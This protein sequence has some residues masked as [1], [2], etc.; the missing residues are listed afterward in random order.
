MDVSPGI[1][2][3]RLPGD[4]GWMSPQMIGDGRWYLIF[5]L[6]GPSMCYSNAAPVHACAFLFHSDVDFS[7]PTHLKIKG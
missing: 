7:A 3:G 1:E 2:D 6:S 4:R 5:C